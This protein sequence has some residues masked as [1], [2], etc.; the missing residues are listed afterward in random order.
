[1]ERNY[2]I[3]DRVEWETLNGTG[4]GEVVERDRFGLNLMTV[5]LDGSARRVLVHMRSARPAD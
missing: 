4:R 3:G 1:M 2:D 5:R